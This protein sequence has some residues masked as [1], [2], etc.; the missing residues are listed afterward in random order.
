MVTY[1]LGKPHP[2]QDKK[3]ILCCGPYPPEGMSL[4][5]AG[6]FSPR[7][8]IVRYR[9]RLTVCPNKF[10]LIQKGVLTYKQKVKKGKWLDWEST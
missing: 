8:M 5:A 1:G 4:E 2:E 10:K 9:T 6:N 3:G 7:W